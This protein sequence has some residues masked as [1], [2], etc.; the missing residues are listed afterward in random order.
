[1]YT[2]A[3]SFNSSTDSSGM[4]N[5]KSFFA[6]DI[7][8]YLIA[9]RV[10]SDIFITLLSSLAQVSHF[11]PLSFMLKCVMFSFAPHDVH[12]KMFGVNPY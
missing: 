10:A 9:Y 6:S 4:V 7:M 12:S 3:T 5:E 2:L 8:A 11:I 1:M